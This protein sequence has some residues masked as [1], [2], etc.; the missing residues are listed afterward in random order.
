MTPPVICVITAT[1]ISRTRTA[2]LCR[3]TALMIESDILKVPGIRHGF[4]TRRGGVSSGDYASLNCGLGSRDNADDVRENRARVVSRLGAADL[5]TAYQ[6]HSAVAVVADAPWAKAPEAD[7]VVTAP[8]G[9]AVGVL[10]ADCAPILLADPEAKVIGAAH[11]GW[12]GAKNGVIAAVIAAMERLGAGRERI[13]AVIGPAISQA[14]YEVGPEFEAA[15]VGDKPE[16]E[17]YFRRLQDNRPYFDLPAF[18]HAQLTEAG[19]GAIEDL[20]LCTYSNESL[21]F[22]F[23]RATHQFD[24]DYG[25]QISAI[26]IL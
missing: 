18:C 19:A 14:A 1:G 6:V 22:S 13:R 10:T 4:F 8:P 3:R 21:F 17:R 5:V 15:F 25:R 2:H 24:A 16:N 26:L 20:R 11:A 12:R 23:R 7:A 9:L